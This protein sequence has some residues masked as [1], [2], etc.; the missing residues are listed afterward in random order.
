MKYMKRDPKARARTELPV[1]EDSSG[2][3]LLLDPRDTPRAP[4]G[5]AGSA[6]GRAKAVLLG[7]RSRPIESPQAVLFMFFMVNASVFRG[8]LCVS[9]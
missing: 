8:V 5:K 1:F 2:E 3:S 9:A 4:L 7:A 6:G